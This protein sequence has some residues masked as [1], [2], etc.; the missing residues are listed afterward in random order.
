VQEIVVTW[1]VQRPFALRWKSFVLNQTHFAD[2]QGL[3]PKRL[4]VNHLCVLEQLNVLR[5][6]LG[7]LGKQ[8][9]GQCLF[10]KILHLL[11]GPDTKEIVAH[12]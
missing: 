12:Q 8:V 3:C 10:K 4:L 11:F 6:I 7:N 9:F 1:L 2:K 5:L